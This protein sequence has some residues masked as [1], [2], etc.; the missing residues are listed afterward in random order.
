M[1]S[2]NTHDIFLSDISKGVVHV[3]TMSEDDTDYPSDPDYTLELDEGQDMDWNDLY[4]PIGGKNYQLRT[5][6]VFYGKELEVDYVGVV[7]KEG[8]VK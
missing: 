6:I 4:I 3:Y 5:K 1:L 7:Y 2:L 8:R